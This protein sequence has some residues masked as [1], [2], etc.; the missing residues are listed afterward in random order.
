MPNNDTTT[1]RTLRVAGAPLLAAL[2]LLGIALPAATAQTASSDPLANSVAD[3]L[4]KAVFADVEVTRVGEV[5][6]LDGT[7]ATLRQLEVAERIAAK[8]QGVALVDNAL[9]VRWDQQ[10]RGEVLDDLTKALVDPRFHTIFDWVEIEVEQNL[11][12]NHVVLTGWVTEPWKVRSA[13]RKMATIPGVTSV[14]SKIEVLPVSI[15]DDEIRLSAARR[16]YGSSGFFQWAGALDP[17]VHLVVRNGELI[18]KGEV[19]N[20]AEKMLARSLVSSS[21]IPF[22]IVNQLVARSDLRS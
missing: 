6:R 1:H 20:R 21:F 10:P 19:A 11:D 16:L 2:A 4:D 8:T 14:R 13:E 17:P 9:L 15:F 12:G 22:R 5:V 18:L 7:V 3:R